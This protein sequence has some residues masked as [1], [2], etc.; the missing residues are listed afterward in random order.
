MY[1][2]KNFK[3]DVV[4]IIDPPNKVKII[5]YSPKLSGTS[6]VVIPEFPILLKTLIKTAKRF[7]SF[8]K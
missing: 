6:P 1:I 5:K 2:L 3:P 7:K 8:I 4:D